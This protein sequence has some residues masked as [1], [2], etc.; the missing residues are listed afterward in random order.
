MSTPN[1]N[2]AGGLGGGGGCEPPNGVRGEFLKYMGFF[3][4]SEDLFC[5]ILKNFLGVLLQKFSANERPVCNMWLFTAQ[6]CVC[7][8]G[9]PQKLFPI[10]LVRKSDVHWHRYLLCTFTQRRPCSCWTTSGLS[11][12][13]TWT[14]ALHFPT[15]NRCASCFA[16]IFVVPSHDLSCPLHVQLLGS[17]LLWVPPLVAC[18]SKVSI[19]LWQTRQVGSRH[20]RGVSSHANLTCSMQSF[21]SHERKIP[22]LFEL[23]PQ[24]LEF[25]V[26]A[27]CSDACSTCHSVTVGLGNCALLLKTVLAE[28]TPRR[29]KVFL[30]RFCSGVTRLTVCHACPRL[31]SVF[32]SAS[33]AGHWRRV[34]ACAHTC[35]EK[36]EESMI[37]SRSQKTCPD[38]QLSELPL[39]P[40]MKRLSRVLGR[41]F[42][43]WSA[44]ALCTE[45]F[46]GVF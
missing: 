35:K 5:Q 7:L 9:T 46:E 22:R 18:Q 43:F 32:A 12:S 44:S 27:C 19:G 15:T 29:T 11:F 4:T 17:V 13:S 41:S 37:T 3:F 38:I 34:P 14:K 16:W 26:H 1:R 21:L 36:R 30:G 8:D 20:T 39:G 40:E 28:I 24:K 25:R 45:R 23:F 33:V 10:F 2:P 6:S 42:F 31:E